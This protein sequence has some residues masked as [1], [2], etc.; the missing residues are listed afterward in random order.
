MHKPLPVALLLIVLAALI[1]DTLIHSRSV[2]AQSSATVYIDGV[3]Y[4]DLNRDL[5]HGTSLSIK[6]AQVVGF[7]CLSNE[8]F[9]LSK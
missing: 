2:Q 9:I 3:N 7:S 8:C 5:K 1:C 4:R 6:G